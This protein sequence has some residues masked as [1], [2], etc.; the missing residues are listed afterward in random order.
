MLSERSQSLEAH[1]K[2]SRYLRNAKNQTQ[3]DHEV[4]R[5]SY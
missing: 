5:L 3:H 4:V 2:G 1:C